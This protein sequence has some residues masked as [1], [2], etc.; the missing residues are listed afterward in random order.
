MT[1]NDYQVAAM[2]TANWECFDILNVALGLPGEAGEFS[3]LVKKYKFHHHAFERERMLEE[4]GDALWYISLGAAV[5]GI[6][7]EELMQMNIDKLWRR[8][9]DGFDPERSRNRDDSL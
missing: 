1:G 8:Y 5:L 4:L 6:S 3:D 7:L 2:R 9:P